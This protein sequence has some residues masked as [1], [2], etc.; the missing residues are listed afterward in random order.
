MIREDKH[1]LCFHTDGQTERAGWPQMLGFCPVPVQCLCPGLYDLLVTRFILSTKLYV[2]ALLTWMYTKKMDRPQFA[3]CSWGE[4]EYR[5]LRTSSVSHLLDIIMSCRTYVIQ[6]N[7]RQAE[8][9]GLGNI[10]HGQ[11]REGEPH[12]NWRKLKKPNTWAIFEFVVFVL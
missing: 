8:W 3:S 11:P 10:K 6:E 9:A 5:Y 12:R 1:N 7:T 2:I 4:Q